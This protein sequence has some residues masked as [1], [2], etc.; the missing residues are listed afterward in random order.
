LSTTVFH[1][2][3]DGVL[4]SATYGIKQPN[5]NPK[6]LIRDYELLNSLVEE[7]YGPGVFV[8]PPQ[9]FGI[10]TYTF[11]PEIREKL[12][13]HRLA[14]PCGP[15][16]SA[17]MR[18]TY[19]KSNRT[20]IHHAS[21]G[22]RSVVTNI[23]MYMRTEDYLRG[24]KRSRLGYDEDD[25]LETEALSDQARSYAAQGRYAEA[26]PLYRQVLAIEDQHADAQNGLGILY[27]KGQGVPQDFAV[28]LEWISKAAEQG[29]AGALSNL[30][31]SLRNAA[32]KGETEK[33]LDL[34]EVGA[35][36]N[37]KNEKGFTALM[38][39]ATPGHASVVDIL[40]EVGADV[41]AEND[42]QATA[43]M[44][45]VMGGSTETVMALTQA[46]ADVN[47]VSAFGNTALTIAAGKSDGA[48]IVEILR[49]AGADVDDKN[50]IR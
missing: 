48:E 39:A 32:R 35:D 36:V 37:A 38:S 9:G 25:A 3:T 12:L 11:T 26:E 42:Q 20:I 49:D 45:A 40:I 14:T 10:Q 47:A 16:S 44:Y 50:E 43:L 34:L 46:G 8:R 22:D 1:T 41:N 31:R 7:K 21:Y 27:L 24:V 33:V 6:G 2:F 4:T 28:G 17:G 15:P 18:C 13:K 23:I 19:W 29:H 5:E 30:D